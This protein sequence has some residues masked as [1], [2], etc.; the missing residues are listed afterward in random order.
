MD[1]KFQEVYGKVSAGGRQVEVKEI[2]LTGDRLYFVIEQTV[3][4]QFVPMRFDGRVNG[5]FITGNIESGT[6]SGTTVI[7]WKASRDPSTVTP[8]EVW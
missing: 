3:K 6:G 5:N 8:L 7:S 4:K 2:K 1:Q